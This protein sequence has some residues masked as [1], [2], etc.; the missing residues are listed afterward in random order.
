MD[1]VPGDFVSWKSS[2]SPP[3]RA[4]FGMY[5]LVFDVGDGNEVYCYFGGDGRL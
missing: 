4:S 3:G 1:L 2:L 5:H